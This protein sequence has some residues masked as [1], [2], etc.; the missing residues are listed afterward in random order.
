LRCREKL[1]WTRTTPIDF[2]NTN[3]ERAR[4]RAIVLVG[5]GP[6][7]IPPSIATSRSHER[8]HPKAEP[9]DFRFV[10]RPAAGLARLASGLSTSIRKSE[11]S[12]EVTLDSPG[13]KTERRNQSLLGAFRA[14]VVVGA[15]QCLVLEDHASRET[16]RG[17][18]SASA[19]RREPVSKEPECFPPFARGGPRLSPS[20]L[21]ACPLTLLS[22]ERCKVMYRHV[23]VTASLAHLEVSLEPDRLFDPGLR[24]PP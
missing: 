19:P 1:L 23:P 4:P 10:S 16:N 3:D 22:K 2:C 6:Q 14:P 15:A 11:L 7:S 12:L 17:S 5:S 9:R 21:S 18:L 8:E 20:D 24:C 13:R